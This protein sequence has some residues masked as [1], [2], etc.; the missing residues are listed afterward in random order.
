MA[1]G[2]YG[3]VKFKCTAHIP[4]FP[5]RQGCRASDKGELA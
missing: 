3:N 5:V 2:A 1:V 4:S